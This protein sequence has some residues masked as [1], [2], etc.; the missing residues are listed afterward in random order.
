MDSDLLQTRHGCGERDASRVVSQVPV[1]RGGG[2]GGYEDRTAARFEIF[3][4]SDGRY[5]TTAL[6]NFS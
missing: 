1:G 6:L 3:V 4:K 5:F 2:G